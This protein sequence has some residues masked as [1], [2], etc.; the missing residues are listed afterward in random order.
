MKIHADV[1]AVSRQTFLLSVF[2]TEKNICESSTVCISLSRSL[3]L[4]LSPD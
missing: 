2:I 1:S 3:A 4:S